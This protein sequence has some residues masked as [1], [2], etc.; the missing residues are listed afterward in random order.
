M[1]GQRLEVSTSLARAQRRVSRC[2]AWLS[3]RGGAPL[4]TSHQVIVQIAHTTR[5]G[6]RIRLPCVSSTVARQP[7]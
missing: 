1:G 3:D 2:A 7:V 6:R 5:A 4:G